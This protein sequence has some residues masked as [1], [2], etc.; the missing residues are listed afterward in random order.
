MSKS[1]DYGKVVFWNEDG[2]YGFVR[3]D[4]GSRDVFV[5]VSS[6]SGEEPT[7]GDRVTMRNRCI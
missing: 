2:G 5:H 3:P 1:S 7:I 6:L 4:D